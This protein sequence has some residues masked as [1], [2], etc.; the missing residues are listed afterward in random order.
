MAVMAKSEYSPKAV[1]DD[2]S[3]LLVFENATTKVSYRFMAVWE[4]DQSRTKD[5][6]GFKVMV[7]QAAAKE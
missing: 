3:H 1:E 7:E 2:L 4:R 6:A 5:A